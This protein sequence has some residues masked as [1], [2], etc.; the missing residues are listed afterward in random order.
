MKTIFAIISLVA[1]F[2]SCEKPQMERV[3]EG[4]D[5]V[6]TFNILG[7]ISVSED[8]LTRSTPSTNDLY[9]VQVYKGNVR[10]AS[11]IFDDMSLAKLNLKMGSAYSVRICMIRDL[12]TKITFF[13][14]VSLM[15]LEKT[16]LTCGIFRQNRVVSSTKL[17]NRD[18]T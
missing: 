15:N 1:L 13:L 17:Q 14:T 12:F 7:D 3:E 16:V 10:F 9:A 11:G 18:W 2:P 5:C 6:V 8:D 4:Q